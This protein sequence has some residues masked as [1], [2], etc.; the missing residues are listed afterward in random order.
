MDSEKVHNTPSEVFAEEDVVAVEGP[1]GVSV[2]MT[3]EAAE[4][5][6]DRL[7]K[8]AAAAHGHQVRAE[9]AREDAKQRRY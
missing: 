4:E 8:A 6:S 7:L 1:N 9:R 2:L 3:P 5:T